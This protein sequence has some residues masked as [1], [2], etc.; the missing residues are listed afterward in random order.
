MKRYVI[1]KDLVMRNRKSNNP[2]MKD[3]ARE[4]GVSLGTVSKVVN[5][6]P[7]GEEYVQRV[8]EAIRRLNYHVNIYAQ[9]LKASRT[10]TVAVLIPDTA[11][12]FYGAL[13]YYLN[14]ALLKRGYRMLL[15]CSG[16]DINQEQ[17]YINM[18]QQNKVDGIIALTYNSDLQ[19]DESIPFVSIDRTIGPSTPCVASDNFA[20]GS[21]AAERLYELGCRRACF[22]RS[23]SDLR[24]EPNKRK[25]GFENGCATVGL[26]YDEMILHDGDPISMF[27]EFL[28][29][30]Y[31]DGQLDYDGIFCVTD[32]L[33]H[34][35]RLILEGMQI[36]VPEDVQMIGYDGTRHFHDKEYTCSTIVQPIEAMAE[37]SVELLLNDSV[38]SIRTPLI[39]LPV[40]Y[41]AGGTTRE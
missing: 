9:G 40:T 29:S 20:G 11:H 35:I 15:C 4:A 39:C 31:H 21:L 33:L 17:E 22:L 28:Q 8:N 27:K 1:R 16:T 32:G 24:N 36:R 41:A 6:I 26:D 25:A 2:T 7:V 18:V 19:V 23:G 13:T 30:H 12:P 10:Y 14:L 37:T 3:V 5:G 38:G 34:D